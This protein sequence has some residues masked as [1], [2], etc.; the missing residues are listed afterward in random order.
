MFHPTAISPRL[1]V[2]ECQEAGVGLLIYPFASMHAMAVAVWD[3]LAQ[4]KREDTR[5]Q[6]R[7]E[8]R[9][10]DHPLSDVK[11]L[12]ELAGLSELQD[13]ERAFLPAEEVKARYKESIGL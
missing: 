8:E 13:Y 10:K 4:L 11:K 7:F 1:S 5:A 2:Q 9:N 12:F 3:F 6:V